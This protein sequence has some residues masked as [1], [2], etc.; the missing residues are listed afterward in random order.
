LEGENEQMEL[1]ANEGDSLYLVSGY[2][3]TMVA[4]GIDTISIIT[5]APVTEMPEEYARKQRNL[6]GEY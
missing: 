5:R 1:V 4:T 3:Y 6:R 2:K